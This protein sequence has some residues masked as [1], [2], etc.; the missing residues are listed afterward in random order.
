M[1]LDGRYAVGDRLPA[2]R[3][4]T[5]EFGVGRSSL[6][7]AL[8]MVETKGL[9]RTDH[10]VGVFVVSNEKRIP[11]LRQLLLDEQFTV[12][13]LIE[14]RMPLEDQAAGLAAGRA[15][16]KA[17]KKLRDLV[18]QAAD[19]D[20]SD[21]D[22]IRLDWAL[23]LAIAKAS[24]NRLMVELAKGL[25][26]L[27]FTYSHRVI[28]LPGRRASAHRGHERLVDAIIRGDVRQARKAA[29]EHI[30]EVEQDIQDALVE[31]TPA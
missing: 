27:F 31:D 24:N 25:A 8:K 2:E 17:K 6:R 29:I 12:G 26:P 13:D 1:I 5:E 10:G 7:E 22:F 9:V 21:D 16:A 19:A 30:R 28:A 3:T 14:V 20:L 15:S 11:S 4:L 23:H 18:A